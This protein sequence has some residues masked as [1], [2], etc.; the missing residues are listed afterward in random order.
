MN[1]SFQAPSSNSAHVMDINI[2]EN[3]DRRAI[4]TPREIFCDT[5]YKENLTS[6][7]N[8]PEKETQRI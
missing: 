7:A 2:C 4:E 8:D 3:L 6:L 5:D 1:S